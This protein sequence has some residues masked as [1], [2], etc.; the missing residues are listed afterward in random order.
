M[1]TVKSNTKLSGQRGEIGESRGGKR[2]ALGL[3]HAQSRDRIH[4]QKFGWCGSAALRAD[5]DVY[6]WVGGCGADQ[7]CHNVAFVIDNQAERDTRLPLL[8]QWLAIERHDVIFAAELL[9]QVDR[10]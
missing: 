10:T 4:A 1:E 6:R 9:H 7:A 8:R 5:R 3:K 2:R